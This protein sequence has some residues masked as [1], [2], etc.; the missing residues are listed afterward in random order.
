[1]TLTQAIIRYGNPLISVSPPDFAG[2]TINQGIQDRIVSRINQLGELI[3]SESETSQRQGAFTL[4]YAKANKQVMALLFG[5]PIESEASSSALYMRTFRADQIPAAAVAGQD[6]FGMLADQAT[7]SASYQDEFNRTVE[8]A[9]VDVSAFVA[10]TPDT[11]AQDA[12]GVYLLSDNIVAGRYYVNVF[13]FYPT[14]DNDRLSHDRFGVLEVY[15]RGVIQYQGRK[16]VYQIH[17]SE[18]ELNRQDNS[19]IDPAASPV[20]VNFRDLSQNC[21][22]DVK[23]LNRTVVC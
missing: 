17:F 7:S 11:F 6:G 16:E 8:L 5:S 23:W 14:T 3:F 4:N 10:G 1:M 19:Q 2:G 12:D 13:G 18:A 22:M 15:L 21:V 9:R 20:A